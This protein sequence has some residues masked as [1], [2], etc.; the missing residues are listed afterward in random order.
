MSSSRLMRL[1][2]LAD[3]VGGSLFVIADLLTL[4]RDPNDFIETVTWAS[5]TKIVSSI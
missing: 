3:L 1:G 4:A 2:G 5:T